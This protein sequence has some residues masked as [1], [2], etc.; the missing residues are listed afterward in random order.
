MPSMDEAHALVI[1]IANYR[2]IT[3]CQSGTQRRS[4]IH[5]LLSIPPTC[6]YPKETHTVEGRDGKP[7]Q[8][9]RRVG[10]TGP[11]QQEE[12]DRLP[13]HSS[14]GGQIE[15]GPNAGAYLLPVD[16]STPRRSPSLTQQSRVTSSRIAARHP[17]PQMV[18]VFDAATR[19]ASG[20][21]RTRPHPSSR[22]ARELP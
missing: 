20:S 13:L 3:S 6:G 11:A 8:H 9:P 16:T 14:H 1:G 4:G 10:G 15:S 12:V 21:P 18:I 7:G 5:D 2:S 22:P 17:R 19:A